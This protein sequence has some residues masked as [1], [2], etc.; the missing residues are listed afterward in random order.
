MLKIL[1]ARRQ[2]YMNHELPDVQTGFRKGRRTRNQTANI[3]W[4]IKNAREFQKKQLFLLYWLCQSLYCVGHSKLWEILKVLGISNYLTWLMRNLYGGQET[5][6]R[7]RHGT[8]D[9]FQDGKG[10]RQG[11]ILLPCLF[12]LYAEYSM[13]NV[14]LDEA[15]AEIKI[16]GEILI[17]SYMQMIPPLCQKA[18]KN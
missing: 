1:H 14:K 3:C 15:Q 17:T 2:Q 7:T 10:L 11:W 4:I 12:N 6:V 8:M 5:T 9:W 16:P 13:W 18:K